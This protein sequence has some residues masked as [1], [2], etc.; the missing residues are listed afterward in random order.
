M[1]QLLPRDELCA[2]APLGL[3]GVRRPGDHFSVAEV[4]GHSALF[5]AAVEQQPHRFLS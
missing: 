1:R 4:E 3:T 2:G 5:Q